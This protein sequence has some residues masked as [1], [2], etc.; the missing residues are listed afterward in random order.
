MPFLA[1]WIRK[2]RTCLTASIV[3]MVELKRPSQTVAFVSEILSKHMSQDKALSLDTVLGDGRFAHD[4]PITVGSA[5]QLGLPVSI[6]MPSTIYELM[7]LYPQA[8]SGRPSVLYVP[9]RHFGGEEG[10]PERS[11]PSRAGRNVD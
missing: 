4:F 9:L 6:D 1:Q 3:T 11:S 7:D 8:G 5:R 10:S 2:S